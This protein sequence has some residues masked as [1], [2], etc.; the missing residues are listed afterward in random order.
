MHSPAPSKFW[1]SGSLPA[2]PEPPLEVPIS[3]Y[4]PQGGSKDT[5]TPLNKGT[6]AHSLATTQ[7]VSRR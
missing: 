4:W 7:L 5:S 2:L 1:Q 3:L 6:K